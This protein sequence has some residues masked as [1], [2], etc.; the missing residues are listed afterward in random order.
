MSGDAFGRIAEQVYA[1]HRRADIASAVDS[2]AVLVPR[3][4]DG[5][6]TMA[7]QALDCL[8]MG[9]MMEVR[10][11]DADPAVWGTV[12]AARGRLDCETKDF[13][14]GYVPDVTGMG[15]M[16]AVYLMEKAGMKVSLSGV[17]KVHSQ[18]VRPGSVVK[19]GATVHLSL[20]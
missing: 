1:K 7:A 8:G 16:D 9:G 20:K 4:M 18:S 2:G 11:S 13:T 10:P 5:N 15:A 17:G 14:P 19:R 12:D 3:V 6:L